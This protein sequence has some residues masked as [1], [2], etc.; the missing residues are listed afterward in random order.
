MK[1]KGKPNDLIER[2]QNDPT[3]AQVDLKSVM[4]AENYIGRAPQQVDEFLREVV[5]PLKRK[6]GK[7]AKVRDVELKV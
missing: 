2:L 1:L 4:K 6:L 3:F 5:A 7:Y